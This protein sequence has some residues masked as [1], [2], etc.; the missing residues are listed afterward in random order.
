MLIFKLPREYIYR[1]SKKNNN[2]KACG[3]VLVG[4]KKII[5]KKSFWDKP[6]ILLS[7]A[8]EESAICYFASSNQ[9]S[10][11]IMIKLS[12]T[13]KI[14]KCGDVYVIYDTNMLQCIIS[15][16]QRPLLVVLNAYGSL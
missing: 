10:F 3:F 7:R 9:R 14:C 13:V 1:V 4:L 11:A 12:K 5:I 8:D 2:N 15:I 16:T 6:G